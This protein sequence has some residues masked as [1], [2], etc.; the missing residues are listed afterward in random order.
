M[1][2]EGGIME[3]YQ[4][5]PFRIKKDSEYQKYLNH[6]KINLHVQGKKL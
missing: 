4:K 3:E 1:F 5:H 2:D 6:L